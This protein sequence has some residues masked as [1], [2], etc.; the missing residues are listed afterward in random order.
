MFIYTSLT[1]QYKIFFIRLVCTLVVFFAT[2]S[3]VSAVPLISKESELKIGVSGDKEVIL[4]Y[5]IY[6]DKTLQLYVNNIGQNLI[7]K[8]SNREFRKFY[9]KI[10]DS[11]EINAFALPGGYVYLTRGLLAALNS[12]A[13]LASVIGHEISHITLHHGAKMMVRSIGSQILSLGGIIASPKNAGKWLMISSSLFQQI[14]MGYGR[15]AELDADA[16]GMMNS[17]D[18]GYKPLAMLKFLKNLRN[19][20]IMSGQSYHGFQASHPDTR[21]RIVKAKLLGDSLSRKYP[22]TK[23][24]QNVYLNHLKGLTYD[25]KKHKKDK[26]KYK[27]KY[28]E[29][30]KVKKGDTLTSISLKLFNDDRHSLEISII[31]GIKENSTLAPGLMLKIITNGIYIK[32]K[33]IKPYKSSL[34]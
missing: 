6:Q 23:Q 34:G 5:G 4:Q 22:N 13:E 29:I 28:L 14:N 9:F 33:P 25:G 32:P 15:S 16:Q 19:Q 17:V 30:Y 8:L 26:R 11:S 18:A 27:P 3:L 20:E 7:R 2:F 10:V 1:N 12:E 31:N 24:N 21:E